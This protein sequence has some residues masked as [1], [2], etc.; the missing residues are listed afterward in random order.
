MK[1]AKTIVFSFVVFL[2]SGLFTVYAA[3]VV[4]TAPELYYPAL[5]TVAGNPFG[6]ISIVEFFDYRCSYCRKLVPVLQNLIANNA[7]VRVVYRDYP[8]LG[9]NSILAARVALAAKLQ[10]QY[11]PLHLAF[12]ASPMPLDQ[13]VIAA[14]AQHLGVSVQQINRALNSDIITQ[15]LEENAGFASQ[16]HVD[17]IP[18]LF[19]AVTPDAKSMAPVQAEEL[20]SPSALELQHEVT[21][22]MDN[23]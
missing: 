19:V 23:N 2:L 3:A 22:L 8:L 5:N 16:L 14:I 6:K 12:F 4:T 17:G 13:S 18:T 10:R 15:Q 20:I 1:V 9:E 7:Q 21:T 11:L